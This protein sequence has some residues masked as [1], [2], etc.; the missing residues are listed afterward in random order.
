MVHTNC[1]G[2]YL[3]DDDQINSPQQYKTLQRTALGKVA[4]SM[5]V[6]Y[7]KYITHFRFQHF[8]REDP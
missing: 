7:K 8:T 1:L 4:H 6:G 2:R 5:S 3:P